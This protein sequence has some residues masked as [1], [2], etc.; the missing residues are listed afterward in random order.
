MDRKRYYPAITRPCPAPPEI[1]PT[2]RTAWCEHC[3]RQ[4]HNLS[5]M[6]V[7]EQRELL[8]R[9]RDP[10]VSYRKA[11]PVA[12]VTAAMSLGAAAAMADEVPRSLQDDDDV[13]VLTEV[14][15]L[16]GVSGGP[17]IEELFRESAL[18]EPVDRD[19]LTDPAEPAGHG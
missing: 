8:A 6:S 1:S 9:E 5:A 14:I 13:E 3:D 4:V 15:F 16:G 11:L 18:P 7:H 10:C 19:R 2:E 12:I 17:F